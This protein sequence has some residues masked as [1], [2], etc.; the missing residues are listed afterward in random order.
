MRLRFLS[1]HEQ[2]EAARYRALRADCSIEGLAVLIIRDQIRP[3][4]QL[5]TTSISSRLAR[6]VTLFVKS[7]TIA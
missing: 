2:R 3:T 1:F 5:S 6:A 7:S 4:R